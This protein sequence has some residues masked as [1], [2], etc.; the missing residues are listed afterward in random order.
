MKPYSM[1][2]KEGK[3][4]P[5]LLIL[6]VIGGGVWLFFS[7][8]KSRTLDQLFRENKRLK[9]ALSNLTEEDQIGYAKVLKQEKKNGRLMTT[10]RFV[11]TARSNKDDIVLSKEY[12]IQGD[13]VYFDALIVKFDSKMVMDGT[14]RSLYLWR[15]IYGENTAP[16]DGHEIEKAGKE[17][18]R[19][20]GFL[21]SDPF[22]YRLLGQ[23]GDAERFWSAI[24]DLSNDPEKL[25][26]YGITAIYGNAVY[27][28]LRPGFIYV[29]KIRNTGEVYPETVPDM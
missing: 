16:K 23:P 22:W 28:K 2:E 29:F 19:Y 4:W 12:I 25:N 17:P 6:I 14:R 8:G 3:I 27:K 20:E 24:W 21:G 13:V 1:H 5:V 10:L 18:K 15:R 26:E 7:F 11:E 9:K